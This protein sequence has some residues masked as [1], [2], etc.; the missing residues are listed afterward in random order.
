MRISSRTVGRT[1]ADFVG[2]PEGGDLGDDVLLEGFELGIGDGDAVELLEQVG[3]AAAL[4][5]DGAA[6]DLSGVRGEDGRDADAL[7]QG[8][9]LVGGDAGEAHAGA[10]LRADAVNR[11]GV[12][13]WGRVGW[14]GGGACGGWSRRG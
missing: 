9:G 11:A 13:R 4:E 2:L 5:H 6:G 1:L 8:A 3:D 14:R 10:G 7:E 12:R